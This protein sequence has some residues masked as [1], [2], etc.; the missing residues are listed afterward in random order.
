MAKIVAK[1]RT[2]LH[3]DAELHRRLNIAAVSMVSKRP[4]SE[5]V[6]SLIRQFLDSGQGDFDK[7]LPAK[8]V[9]RM[10]VN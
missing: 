7:L 4:M 6:E 5:I 3:I 1:M 10:K 2:T 8:S 9:S